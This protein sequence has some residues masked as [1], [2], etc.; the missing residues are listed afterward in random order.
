MSK[1]ASLSSE[2]PAPA[3]KWGDSAVADGIGAIDWSET[4][5]GPAS[6]WPEDLRQVLRA[7]LETPDPR[8]LWWGESGLTFYNDAALAL[9]GAAHPQ[10]LGQPAEQARFCDGTKIPFNGKTDQSAEPLAVTVQRHSFA[11]EA[12][13]TFTYRAVA[14]GVVGAATEVTERILNQR[15]MGI[16]RRLAGI[17]ARTA[18]QACRAA[19][20]IIEEQPRD[21]SF[22][23]IYM[24]NAGEKQARLMRRIGIAASDPYAP[25]LI[26]LEHPSDCPW[27]LARVLQGKAEKIFG[28]DRA[29]KLPGGFWPEPARS[30]VLVPFSGAERLDGFTIVGASPR[31]AL[32]SSYADF[33]E[34]FTAALAGALAQARS[35]EQSRAQRETATLLENL[36]HRDAERA[37]EARA[38]GQLYRLSAQLLRPASLRDALTQILDASIELLGA[39]LGNVQIHEAERNELRTIA[40][41]GFSTEFLTYFEKVT[42]ADGS[43]CGM[44]LAKRAA[45]LIEDTERDEKFRPH[46]AMAAK[47]GF[48]AVFSVPLISRRGDVLGVLSTHWREPRRPE[49]REVR[50]LELYAGHAVDAIERIGAE[51][52]RRESEIDRQKFVSL[53]ENCTDFIGM[54]GSDGRVLY[55]NPAGRDLIGLDSEAAMCQTR[56][57]DYLATD[58][59]GYESEI[60][61]KVRSSGQWEGEIAFKHVKTGVVLPV[62]Q[63]V[64]Q[65][66]YPNDAGALCFATVARDIS[67]RKQSEIMLRASEERFRIATRAGKVGV[68]DWDIVRNRISW[69]ESLYAMHGVKPEAFNATLESY[70]ALIHPDDSARVSEEIARCL[71]TGGTYEIEFRILRPDGQIVWIFTDGTVIREDER[72]VRM[73]GATVDI[74]EHKRLEEALRQSERKLRDQAQQLEQQLIASGRL[75]SLGEVTASMAHEFNNPLG[76][77]IG[78]VEDLL[79]G[80]KAGDAEFHALKIIEEE[81]RR[82]KKIVQDLMEYARPKN[83]EMAPTQ[84]AN[85]ISRCIQLLET[86]FYK[87]RVEA[88]TEI[89]PALPRIYADAQQLTQVLVN[90]FLNAIDAMPA[91]GKIIVTAE[92]D[93]EGTPPALVLSVADN[94]IGIEKDFLP[95]IFQPFYTAKKR[96]GLGLGLP[97]CERIITNHRGRIEVKSRPGEGTTFTVYLPF[98]QPAKR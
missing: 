12:H 54:A 23:L 30:A 65:I 2:N 11:E 72:P 10:A 49:E 3:E 26:D 89:D 33:L 42:A 6:G 41:R 58:V 57:V 97:I 17:Q 64:F 1:Q 75:I 4:P 34:L 50:M 71:E 5:L 60:L 19:A 55:I 18:D 48:R 63:V 43:A 14:G 69:S 76:I 87:Q 37:Q 78:F 53:V 80:K 27:P 13:F 51:E 59:R 38:V 94:G 28:L 21:F 96:R 90:L 85:V 98:E 86:H 61:D 22:A 35:H 88:I 52:A 62:Y 40:Q 77:I 36:K 29:A 7:I 66:R 31:L 79:G 15:R 84:V 47:A 74:T 82:C 16:L 95:K 67:R 20:Q 92:L 25:T 46:R 39:D 73:L 44:A 24:I 70:A 81:S 91:G 93:A 83:A 45:V 32:D 68:W 9:L 56:I 8:F